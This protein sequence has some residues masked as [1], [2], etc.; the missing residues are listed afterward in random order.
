MKSTKTRH[1]AHTKMQPASI[2]DVNIPHTPGKLSFD[3]FFR[4]RIRPPIILF[5]QGIVTLVREAE[6]ET[7][8]RNT[9]FHCV[10][11]WQT[12]GEHFGKGISVIR[13]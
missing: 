3:T 8:I 9:R 6:G 4:T 7:L 10:G 1:E 2:Y 12:S 13:N 5:R 11:G